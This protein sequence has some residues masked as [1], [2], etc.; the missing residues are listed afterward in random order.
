MIDYKNFKTDCNNII[1]TYLSSFGFRL[2]SINEEDFIIFYT[3]NKIKLMISMLDN[4]P[5]VG[6]SWE[7]IGMNLK[8]IKSSFIDDK[9]K[10]DQKEEMRFY[11]MFKEQNDLND[12]PTQM[13]YATATME[14]FYKPILTGEVRLEDVIDEESA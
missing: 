11:K 7:F 1:S 9:L 6:V 14:K 5:H 4:F 8:R 3:N 2:D 12:Y 13:R 10:I